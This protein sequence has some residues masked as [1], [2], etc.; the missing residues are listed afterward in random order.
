M[1]FLSFWFTFS[2]LV[3]NVYMLVVA[4]MD[5]EVMV[6]M[7]VMHQEQQ[8]RKKVLVSDIRE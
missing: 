4:I 7:K 8:N 3:L 1:Q 2:F 6:A 5:H